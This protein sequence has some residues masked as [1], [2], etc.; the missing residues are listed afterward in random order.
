M[1]R[2]RV[3]TAAMAVAMAVSGVFAVSASTVGAADPPHTGWVLIGS[4]TF[5]ETTS[6]CPAGFVR[7]AP[8]AVEGEPVIRV[9][10]VDAGCKPLVETGVGVRG[11]DITLDW[12]KRQELAAAGRE[13]GWLIDPAEGDTTVG[14]WESTCVLAPT[15][16]DGF[17][18]GTFKVIG[19]CDATMPAGPVPAN[20]R[21]VEF[22]MFAE[23]DLA[24]PTTVPT[25]TTTSPT[26][27]TTAP[28]V[29]RLS[30]LD[31]KSIDEIRMAVDYKTTD[32]DIL[33]LYR[34]L[35][36]REPDVEGALYWIRQAR[37][38]VSYDDLAWSVI[39]S[40][41]F[42]TLFGDN[43]TN[44]E[45]LN[46]VYQNVLGRGPDGDGLIYWGGQM[47]RGLARHLVIRWVA[48]GDEFKANFPYSPISG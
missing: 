30:V 18:D 23:P 28:P 44:G 4:V 42:K 5:E 46:I 16:D 13:S 21:T 9:R 48:A 43:L 47:Q 6:G 7:L 1:R 38:G 45:F 34:A 20:A 8:V 25:S 40:T 10:S 3:A 11:Y 29:R 22:A 2:N 39:A 27:S 24:P 35:L 15:I 41:E 32:A 36:R 12:A 17:V 33:R 26:T 31:A 19:G 37:S 14:A